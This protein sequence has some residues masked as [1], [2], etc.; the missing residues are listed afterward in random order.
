MN[1]V[2]HQLRDVALLVEPL[3]IAEKSH[4]PGFFSIETT[5]TIAAVTCS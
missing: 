4:H 5:A 3:T 1:I 2:P